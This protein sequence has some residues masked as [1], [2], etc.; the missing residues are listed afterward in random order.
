MATETARTPGPERWGRAP[1]P[2]GRGQRATAAHWT[3][4]SGRSQRSWASWTPGQSEHRFTVKHATHVER[5][6]VLMHSG[7][8]RDVCVRA[9]AMCVVSCSCLTEAMLSFTIIWGRSLWGARGATVTLRFH[10]LLSAR[11]FLNDHIELLRLG[12]LDEETSNQKLNSKPS[13]PHASYR[14]RV[15]C[16]RRR[17]GLAALPRTALHIPAEQSHTR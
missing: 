11:L 1:P 13:A 7:G 8:R 10:G 14:V 2:K 9:S 16:R 6:V 4:P 15:P 3:T 17:L 5:S 12:R